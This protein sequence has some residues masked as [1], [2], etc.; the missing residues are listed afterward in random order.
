M[1]FLFLPEFVNFVLGQ[2]KTVRK[3]ANRQEAETRNRKQRAHCRW[4]LKKRET[5]K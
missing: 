4:V 2:R 1:Y 5:L 3:E